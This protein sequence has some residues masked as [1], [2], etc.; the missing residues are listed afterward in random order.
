MTART[1]MHFDVGRAVVACLSM[2]F[3][4]RSVGLPRGLH[5]GGAFGL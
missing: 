4:T 3:D 1:E 5:A 2:M